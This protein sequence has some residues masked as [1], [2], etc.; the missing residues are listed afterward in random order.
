MFL[1]EENFRFVQFELF[2]KICSNK[3]K[4]LSNFPYLSFH[5]DLIIGFPQTNQIV[6]S[7]H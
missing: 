6:K 7:Y 2:T 3:L 4:K 1:L 5:F